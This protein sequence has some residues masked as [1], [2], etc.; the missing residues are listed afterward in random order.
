MTEFKE[1]R[2]RTG[3]R[4]L[5]NVSQAHEFEVEGRF[6]KLNWEQVHALA[7]IHL[8]HVPLADGS[9][10]RVLCSVE[11]CKDYIEWRSS[12]KAQV[13]LAASLVSRPRWR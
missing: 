12:T 7:R 13:R 8:E 5:E 9:N 2:C 10:A 1:I 6:Y 3:T 11:G 4:H